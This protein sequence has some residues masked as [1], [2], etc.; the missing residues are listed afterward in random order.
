M[1]SKLS[2]EM[3]SDFLILPGEPEYRKM[4]EDV[5]CSRNIHSCAGIDVRFNSA[6]LDH[7]FFM[8]ADRAARDKSLFSIERAKRLLWIEKVLQDPDLTVYRGWN[9]S[10]KRYE[11][12]RRTVLVTPDQYVVVTRLIGDTKAA[13]VTAFIPDNKRVVDK[14]KSSPIIYSPGS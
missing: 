11:N 13:F 10:K 12:N 7:G 1:S 3:Y 14:I 9:N 6:T 4:Y 5:Y 2:L 8:N